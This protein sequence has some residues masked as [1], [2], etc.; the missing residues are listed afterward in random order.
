MAFWSNLLGYQATWLLTVWSAG[1]GMAW[2]GMLACVGFVIWQWLASPVRSADSLVL[3]AALACGL[4]I[5]GG[6]ALSGWLQYASPEPALPAP[7]WIV[8]LWGA[9]ALTLN[10]SMRWFS[11]RPWWAALFAGVGGPL[12]YLGAARGFSAV[13]FPDDARAALLFLALTWAAAL[14]LLF[15]ISRGSTRSAFRM[16]RPA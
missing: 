10:H 11:I 5:D 2:I 8:L 9:F 13:T 12:A 14:P 16:E 4:L 6:L 15:R 3:L 1:R 7:L